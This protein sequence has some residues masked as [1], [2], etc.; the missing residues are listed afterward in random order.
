MRPLSAHRAMVTMPLT[1][2]PTQLVMSRSWN[3]RL[4]KA[5][6]LVFLDEVKRV[7]CRST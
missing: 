1:K 7:A 3:I 6:S 4:S 2:K 5:R